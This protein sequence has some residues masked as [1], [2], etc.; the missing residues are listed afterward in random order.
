MVLTNHFI[1]HLVEAGLTLILL[2]PL[3][4]F[5]FTLTTLAVGWACSKRQSQWQS[6]IHNQLSEI[7]INYKDK[8]LYEQIG[9]L[10]GTSFIPLPSCHVGRLLHS[11]FHTLNCISSFTHR[12]VVAMFPQGTGQSHCTSPSLLPSQHFDESLF[13][14]NHIMLFKCLLSLCFLDWTSSKRNSTLEANSLAP[15]SPRDRSTEIR[16]YFWINPSMPKV[17]LRPPTAFM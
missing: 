3:A 11:P 13:S 10:N 16:I 4:L 14:G 1:S 6:G 12:R 7:L 9:R 2:S 17:Q 8:R 15:F 5:H